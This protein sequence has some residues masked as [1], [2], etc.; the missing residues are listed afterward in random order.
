MATNDPLDPGETNRRASDQLRVALAQLDEHI[1]ALTAPTME[2]ALVQKKRATEMGLEERDPSD[3][4]RK[5]VSE[6]GPGAMIG[7]A[8]AGETS[9]DASMPNKPAWAEYLGKSS[10]GGNLPPS[11]MPEAG[12]P[13]RGRTNVEAATLEGKSIEIPQFGDWQVDSLSRLG[14]QFAG[15]NAINKYR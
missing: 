14:A 12:S 7:V 6:A 1:Q 4:F 5:F 11:L 3:L 13:I 15:K 10:G 9:P 8:A 2:L